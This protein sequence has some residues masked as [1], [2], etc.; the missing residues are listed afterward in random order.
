MARTKAYRKLDVD[1]FLLLCKLLGSGDEFL[2]VVV[3]SLVVFFD[4][5]GCR[6]VDL[7]QRFTLLECG[8]V[9][10]RQDALEGTRGA[11]E[12]TRGDL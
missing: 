3:C 10:V 1:T 11:G 7:M 6:V 2:E 4:G 12:G 9:G 8:L 5:N